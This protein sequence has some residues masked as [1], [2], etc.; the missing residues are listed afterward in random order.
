AGVQRLELVAHVRQR[1]VRGDGRAARGRDWGQQ[2]RLP[3]MLDMEV[4]FGL[5]LGLIGEQP[6]GRA[7]EADDDRPF[8]GVGLGFS[9]HGRLSWAPRRPARRL[10]WGMWLSQGLSRA[11]FC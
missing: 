11:G 3:A 10:A 9:G 8:G 4:A 7:I 5:G 1:S 2:V 6:Y